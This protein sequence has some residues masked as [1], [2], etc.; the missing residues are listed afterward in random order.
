MFHFIWLKIVLKP[1][2]FNYI[3]HS[4]FNWID[5]CFQTYKSICENVIEF[6]ERNINSIDT[7]LKNLQ[8]V[9][10]IDQESVVYRSVRNYVFSMRLTMEGLNEKQKCLSVFCKLIFY[11]DIQH[12]SIANIF[13]HYHRVS[14]LFFIV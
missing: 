14:W 6:S 12:Q 10:A 3:Y 11:T 4:T 7:S 2:S 13:K 1:L 5:L 9:L 8:Y